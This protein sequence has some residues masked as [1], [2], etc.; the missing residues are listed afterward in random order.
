MT[1][2]FNSVNIHQLIHKIHNTHI[3]TTRVKFLA[4][5]LKGHQQ[6]TSFNNQTSKYTIIKAEV[7][8]RGVLSPTLFNIYL[9]DIPFPKIN[10][11][12]LISYADD[13][14][15][16]SSHSNTK[17]VIQN[18]LPCPNEI[19]TWAHNNNLQINPIKTT[20]TLITPDLSECYKPLN[21]HINNTPISTI[22]NPTILGL[23]FDPKLKFSTHTDN[24]ITKVKNTQSLK[25][26]YINT[27]GKSKETLITT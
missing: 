4:N 17:T 8:Q 11:L 9:S 21:I 10:S 20:S 6:Y 24:T 23:T 12:N 27:L 13:I 14:T 19:H 5:S 22:S 25:T 1:K 16:T 18:L 15:I 26:P 7:T 2:T 3:P